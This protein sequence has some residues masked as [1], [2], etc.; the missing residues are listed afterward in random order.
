MTKEVYG[1]AINDIETMLRKSEELFKIF[2]IE[3][4]LT[5]IA[6][7]ENALKKAF[8]SL[9]NQ[10]R[11]QERI[12]LENLQRKIQ[13]LNNKSFITALESCITKFNLLVSDKQNLSNLNLDD[14]LRQAERVINSALELKECPLCEQKIVDKDSLLKRVIERYHK[15]IDIREKLN[16]NSREFSV[17]LNVLQQVEKD[18]LEIIQLLDSKKVNH[19]T[20]LKEYADTV[21]NLRQKVDTQYRSRE[22]ITVDLST[23]KENIRKLDLAIKDINSQLVAKIQGLTITKEEEAKHNAYQKILR[24]KSL[25]LEN[26][27][28]QKEIETI[29]HLILSVRLIE[30]QMLEIQNATMSKILDLLS[31]DVNKF[32]CY[33]NRKDKIKD[34][35]LILTGE[36]G[37]E[38]SLEFYDN[39]ASPP[40][41]YLS[42]SQF[43]SLGIAFFLAAVKKFN[44]ANKFFILDDVL[45]S[46]DI[47]YRMRLLDLLA[48]EFADYQ[49]LL[50]THEEYWYEM[51]K[52]K[53]PKWIL[54][55]VSWCFENGIR[56]KDSSLD[57]LLELSER[58]AKGD[59]IGNNLRIYIEFL[60][61]NICVSLNVPLP[62]RL[63]IDNEQRMVGELFSALTASLNK[64]KSNVK[65]KQEYKDLEVSN[66]ITTVSS[67]HNPDFSSIGADME[68]TLEIVRR[69][70]DLFICPKGRIVNREANIPGQDKISC[71]C[72]C[73]QLDWK[74]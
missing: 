47:N 27:G 65:D 21:K 70:R 45:V 29:K 32:F 16:S 64:H 69:F 56:F 25:V 55:E 2:G 71:Q 14:F 38:F 43:N 11:A 28:L 13:E 72:G 54:K 61:K 62:F 33:L 20:S 60:L 7:L 30:T 66:F 4:Q 6:E 1:E 58:R 68:E 41:K 19:D 67:H 15:L 50:F 5:N 22:L 34:V 12:E 49:V 8:D 74:E 37:I 35:K 3:E 57:Q 39:I 73:L 17:L 31:Q 26:I 48:E 51:I 40:Q 59:N 44:K 36:E 24:G 52:R 53:F 18:V 42:E 23:L 63:G 9:P 10:K 46:F